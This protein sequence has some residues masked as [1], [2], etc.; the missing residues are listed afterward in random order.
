MWWRNN[1]SNRPEEVKEPDPR[2]LKFVANEC[3]E[4]LFHC[5]EEIKK[6][7]GKKGGHDCARREER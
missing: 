3:S 1:T 7:E 6:R 5:D 4:R 2:I